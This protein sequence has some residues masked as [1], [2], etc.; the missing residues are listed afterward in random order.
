MAYARSSTGRNKW[1]VDY[2]P[3]FARS[4]VPRTTDALVIPS[5]A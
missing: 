5:A 4:L 2:V 3:R 1:L